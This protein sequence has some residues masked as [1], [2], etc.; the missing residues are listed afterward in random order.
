MQWEGGIADKV[1][2][3]G[4]VDMKEFL[5]GD[6]P[7]ITALIYFGD[8]EKVKAE[9]AA[10][11]E[12]GADII[13]YMLEGYEPE[14]HTESGMRELIEAAHGMPIY[15]TDY[16]NGNKYKEDVT[17]EELKNQLMLFLEL[18]KGKSPVLIDVRTD[19][20]DRVKGEFTLSETAIRRQMD[21]IDEIHANG[22]KVLM[23][24]HSFDSVSTPERVLYLAQEQQR[25]GADIA[26][27]VVTAPTE[28][29]L[30]ENY[31]ISL[32]LKKELNIPYLFLCGGDF[33]YRHRRLSAPLGSCMT[34]VREN[35]FVNEVQPTV[36]EAREIFKCLGYYDN[37]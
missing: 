13:G 14:C 33:S 4:G 20:Y 12:Q 17:D 8:I 36:A 1:P 6:R 19:M 22:G 16:A 27:I 21:F 15:I 26:K 23:S 37:K 30:F 29:D 9:T 7:S 31:E 3:R 35:S 28:K 24:S 25:R 5:K 34:L 11:I 32:R 18:S 2:K 10:V